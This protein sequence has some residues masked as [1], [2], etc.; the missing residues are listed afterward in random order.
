MTVLCLTHPVSISWT[1][2]TILSFND[3]PAALAPSERPFKRR[4]AYS[5]VWILPLVDIK[6]Q[7][8]KSSYGQSPPVKNFLDAR[9]YRMGSSLFLCCLNVFNLQRICPK[10]SVIF[11][12]QILTLK[13]KKQSLGGGTLIFSYISRLGPFLG[14]QNFEFQ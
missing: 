7:Q 9:M 3:R 1:H 11:I 5:S 8:Q 2:Y 13:N 12:M 4:P 14:G 10:N 6:K